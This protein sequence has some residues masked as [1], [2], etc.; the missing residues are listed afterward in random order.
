MSWSVCPVIDSVLQGRLLGHPDFVV[1]GLASDR[2]LFSNGTWNRE[3]LIGEPGHEAINGSLYGLVELV[4]NNPLVCADVFSVPSPGATLGLIGLGPLVRAGLIL[5]DPVVQLS[6][7][8]EAADL[9]AGLHEVGWSGGVV[10]SSDPQELSSVRAAVCM[11]EIDLMDD[12]SDLDGLFEE[13]YGRSFFVRGVD[14][15]E[16]DAE[17]V[18]GLDHAAYSLR[19]SPFEDRALVTVLVM[20]DVD[21][22]CG[23]GQVVHAMN[24]MCGFEECLGLRVPR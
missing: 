20:A 12:F 5:E 22:K 13:S 9:Q 6:F 15:L 1:D 21:G 3:V 19:V 24:V 7:E 8:S 4:D 2:V 17:Q 14:A 11:A 23:A 18:R 10:L 16:W